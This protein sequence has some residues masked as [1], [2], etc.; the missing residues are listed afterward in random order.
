M[1]TVHNDSWNKNQ[2]TFLNIV[3]FTPRK[4]CRMPWHLYAVPEAAGDWLHLDL[5]RPN[6]IS[7]RFGRI[8]FEADWGGSLRLKIQQGTKGCLIDARVLVPK[9]SWRSRTQYTHTHTR[10]QTRPAELHL[11]LGRRLSNWA[12]SAVVDPAGLRLYE[13]VSVEL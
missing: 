9:V 4:D 8:I 6:T 10:T 11:T 2:Q 7:C 13:S 5:N 12:I 3:I 1:S